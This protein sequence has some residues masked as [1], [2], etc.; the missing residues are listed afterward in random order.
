MYYEI[1]HLTEY[2]Y[3]APVQLGN[4][5]LRF[6]PATDANQHLLRF[7]MS[8]EPEPVG[9]SDLSDLDGNHASIAWF[10]GDTTRLRIEAASVVQTL[11]SNP[12][13]YVWQGDAHL[14]V[15]YSGAFREA[16]GPYMARMAPAEVTTIGDQVAKQVDGRAQMF[17][18]RLAA[19]LHQRFGRIV[20]P[21]GEPHEPV[22]TLERGEGS[23]R[24][25]TV[26]YLAVARSQGFAGRFVS[27]YHVDPGTDGQHDL[28]A[29][30]E[31]YVP[32]GGWR[33]FDPTIGLAVADR[34]V[35]AAV[36]ALPQQAA[37]VSGT[38]AGDATSELQTYVEIKPVESLTSR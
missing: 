31:I 5:T 32:G 3:S 4:Q 18:Y 22:E 8:I 19:E 9:M 23:C 26:L 38:Y 28:H 36:G 17:L 6:R 12:F 13:D 7:E 34:H 16:L 33:G 21:V 30:P 15:S 25:L 29:W 24:D 10:L 2:R 11:R 14:P 37:P 1:R 35:S 27:G 20:R